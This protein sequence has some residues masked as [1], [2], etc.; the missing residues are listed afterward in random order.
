MT[1]AIIGAGN[2]GKGLAKRLAAAGEKVALAARDPKKT[3]EV[4]HAIGKG[5]I[6]TAPYA[7]ASNAGI[8]II[9]VPYSALEEALKETGDL[10]GKT[11][12][13]IVNA[14]GPNFSTA[15][16]NTTSVAE[17]VQT[18]LPLA[19][20]VVAFNTVF[21]P[22]LDLGYDGVK[23]PQ[24]FYAG[25]D[26]GAKAKVAALIEKIGFVPYDA[27]PL[28]NAR[29]IEAMANLAIR[30]A[31]ALGRGRKIALGVTQY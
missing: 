10:A 17:E 22:L 6:G 30:L 16:P 12:V 19:K 4:A 21:A 8:V 18:L 5:V 24:V 7:A 11:I 23:P 20:V 15:L 9:A 3:A 26:A 27:G 28:E 2:M 25:D 31:Y 14:V 13:S 1:V 29:Q